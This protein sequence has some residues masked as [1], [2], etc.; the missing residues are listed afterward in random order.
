MLDGMECSRDPLV[1]T[2]ANGQ[3]GRALLRALAEQGHPRVRAL[4]RSDRARATVEAMALSPAPEIHVVDYTSP[5]DMEEA[6]ADAPHV[7]H[8]VGI[9]KELP[10]TG[11][12]EAHEHTCHALALAAARAN[13]ERIVYLSILGARLDSENACLAS[14]GRAEACL[15]DDRT[16]ATILRVPM[17]LGGD[18][19]AS[20]SLRA[21]ARAHSVRLVGGGRTLQQPIDARDVVRAILAAR[22]AAPGRE[23]V[24]DAGG[25]VCLAHRELVLRAARLWGNEPRIRTLPLWAA[26]LG[27]ATLDRLLRQP[28]ITRPMFEILQHDDR[29]DPDPFCEALGIDLTPLDTTLA[30]HVGPGSV[31]PERASARLERADSGRVGSDGDGPND[32]EP[33]HHD[34]RRETPA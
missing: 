7:V 5:H 12:I 3:L 30:D 20:R 16:P 1:V 8:L 10:G 9:I 14:K 2:G 34:P 28:P 27:V 19:P 33:E 17:V 4:V 11:Y 13:T 21:Q 32:A 23:L 24:L 26:R 18:D 15:L 22:F 25:P 31:E 6:I 29:V